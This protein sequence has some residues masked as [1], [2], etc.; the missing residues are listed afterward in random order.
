[1][2][3]PD[4]RVARAMVVPNPRSCS[5]VWFLNDVLQDAQNFPDWESA[6]M[7]A[8]QVYCSLGRSPRS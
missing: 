7:R 2:R 5:F 1:M 8:G 3:L 6:V 4:G